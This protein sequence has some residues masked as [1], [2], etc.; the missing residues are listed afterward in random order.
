[1]HFTAL[2]YSRADGQTS[3]HWLDVGA[4]TWEP[5]FYRYVRDAFAP[6][7]LMVDFWEDRVRAGTGADIRVM[8]VNDLG[9]SWSGPVR[10]RVRRAG[11]NP[12]FEGSW[13]VQLAPFGNGLAEFHLTWPR[14][15]GPVALEAELRG[16]DGQPVRSVRELA[17]T[18]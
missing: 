15:S 7:G 2:G 8:L 13:D 12:L 17:V 10:L 3:D 9:E 18:P 4:L 6:V 11:G 16:A 5:E 14:E 1:M